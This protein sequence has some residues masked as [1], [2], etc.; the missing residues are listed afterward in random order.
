MPYFTIPADA[1]PQDVQKLRVLSVCEEML[2]EDFEHTFTV[3][4]PHGMIC[5]VE[6]DFHDVLIVGIPNLMHPGFL[7]KIFDDSHLLGTTTRLP[8]AC[9]IALKTADKR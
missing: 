5:E 9:S 2:E 6:I 4:P 3:A 1:T 7:W 8:H